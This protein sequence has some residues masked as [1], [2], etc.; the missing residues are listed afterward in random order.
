MGAAVAAVL[1]PPALAATS[2]AAQSGTRAGGLSAGDAERLHA[3]QFDARVRRSVRHFCWL[4]RR[5]VGHR[6][7]VARRI[8]TIRSPTPGRCQ[9]TGIDGSALINDAGPRC[10]SAAVKCSLPTRRSPRPRSPIVWPQLPPSYRKFGVKGAAWAAGKVVLFRGGTY[11]TV[12][13]APETQQQRRAPVDPRL[14]RLRLPRPLQ[15]RLPPRLRYLPRARLPLR[16]R[17][18]STTMR[19]RQPAPRPRRRRRRAH[20]HWPPR[21]IADARRETDRLAYASGEC[22]GGG[23]ANAER[24]N[25]GHCRGDSDRHCTGSGVVHASRDCDRHAWRH[26]HADVNSDADT[27]GER[28]PDD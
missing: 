19:C 27:S 18:R 7:G 21:Q 25:N 28:Q 10:T 26:R 1:S 24:S 16:K 5:A 17:V 9:G 14:R 15:H 22:D 4:G 20:P 11:L 23:D 12:T 3:D 6:P 2:A 8:C 13:V